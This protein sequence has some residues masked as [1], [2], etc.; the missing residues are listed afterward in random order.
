MT[1]Y[2]Y[3]HCNSTH[4]GIARLPAGRA[5]LPMDVRVLQGLHQS[6]DLAH[7][8]PDLVVVDRDV[9]DNT[10]RVD[11]EETSARTKKHLVVMIHLLLLLQIMNGT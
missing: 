6:Q 10:S 7:R 4:S 2:K 3:I 9:P 1:M 5:A 11:Y 8:T